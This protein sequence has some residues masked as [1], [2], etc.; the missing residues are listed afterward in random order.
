MADIIVTTPKSEMQRAAEEAASIK[1]DNGGFY[2]R[3]FRSRPCMIEPGNKIWYVEDGYLRGYCVVKEIKH[4][5]KMQCDTT[6]KWWPQGFY[7]FMDATTWQW[8]K[9]I[10]YKGFQGYRR[11]D[12]I[13]NY[14]TIGD[15]K[16]LK[17]Q[18]QL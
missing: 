1:K 6:G 7:A 9:P 11:A 13:L 2:F 17:P 12:S 15:W 18:I 14:E 4:L 8:I 3:R 10:P 5:I 16:T